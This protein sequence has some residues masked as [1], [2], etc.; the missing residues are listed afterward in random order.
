MLL[1]DAFILMFFYS[2]EGMR[3]PLSVFLLKDYSFT[4]IWQTNFSLEC[5]D[6][7]CWELTPYFFASYC[8]YRNAGWKKNLW[9]LVHFVSSSICYPGFIPFLFPFFPPFPM[10]LNCFNWIYFCWTIFFNFFLPFGDCLNPGTAKDHYLWK[11]S[12]C[13][14]MSK[15]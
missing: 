10:V 1:D 6:Y 15:V 8:L 11:L 12:K 14:W 2:G 13:C 7:H 9:L 4:I 5:H 3:S